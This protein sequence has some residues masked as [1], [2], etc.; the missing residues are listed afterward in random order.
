MYS[1][2]N[3]HFTSR[4]PIASQGTSVGASS[5]GSNLGGQSARD[6]EVARAAVYDRDGSKARRDEERRLQAATNDFDL[7]K[8]HHRFIRDDEESPQSYGD[9][10]VSQSLYQP[11]GTFR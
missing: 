11:R 9:A 5:R 6:R 8:R 3:E 4:A 10:V 2:T 1:H 7:L